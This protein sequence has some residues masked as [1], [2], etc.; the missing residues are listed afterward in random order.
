LSTS[1]TST[2]WLI[3]AR[4]SRTLRRRGGLLCAASEQIRRT[5][6]LLRVPSLQLIDV[7]LDSL[8]LLQVLLLVP[9]SGRLL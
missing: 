4:R 2:T 1:A 9:G 5:L 8:M 6:L 7:L 3:G